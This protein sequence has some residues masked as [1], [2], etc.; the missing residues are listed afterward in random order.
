MMKK[1]YLIFYF[2]GFLD[3]VLA[4]LNMKPNKAAALILFLLGFVMLVIGL[5]SKK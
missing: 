5:K 4:I 2:V 3:F 1:T